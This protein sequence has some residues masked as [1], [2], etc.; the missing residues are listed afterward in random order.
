MANMLAY[1][2]S[3]CSRT[4]AL[5]LTTSRPRALS[6]VLGVSLNSTPVLEDQISGERYFREPPALAFGAVFLISQILEIYTEEVRPHLV[7]YLVRLSIW[8]TS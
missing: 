7:R 1:V 6:F 2:N 4:L 3:Q 8:Y 5:E